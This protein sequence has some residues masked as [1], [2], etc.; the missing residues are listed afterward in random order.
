M[1]S[2]RIYKLSFYRGHSN[3]RPDNT[4][5]DLKDPALAVG[6]GVRATHVTGPTRGGDGGSGIVSH[7]VV[8]HSAANYH[9][10]QLQRR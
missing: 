9:R 2:R 10:H 4:A 8:D 5:I 3:T 6:G 7:V 1:V